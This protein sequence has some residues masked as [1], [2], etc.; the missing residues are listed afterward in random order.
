M[1]KSH[2]IPLSFCIPQVIKRDIGKEYLCI[3]KHVWT[4]FKDG[5]EIPE[6]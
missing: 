6:F 5:K 4:Y 3:T 2:N 1:K